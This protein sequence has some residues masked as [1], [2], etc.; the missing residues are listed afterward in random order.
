MPGA[1]FFFDKS[2]QFEGDERG[3]HLARGAGGTAK[4]LVAGHRFFKHIPDNQFCIFE[5]A[6]RRALGCAFARR[7]PE[8]FEDV[9]R[10]SDECGAEPDEEMRTEGVRVADSV[11]DAEQVAIV[12]ACEPCGEDRAGLR[13]RLDGKHGVGE[14]DHEPVA[15]G[16]VIHARGFIGRILGEESAAG[17]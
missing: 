4:N 12:L 13:T 15:L 10:F 5:V 8:C 11:R 3:Q 6:R 9:E 17:L 7:Y 2:T 1:E 14:S 16:E